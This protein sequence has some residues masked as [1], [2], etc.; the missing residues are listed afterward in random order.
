MKAKKSYYAGIQASYAQKCQNC[1]H[2][3][4]HHI[5]TTDERHGAYELCRE[6]DCKCPKWSTPWPGRT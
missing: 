5:V 6:P 1:G 4:G 3:E 2:S